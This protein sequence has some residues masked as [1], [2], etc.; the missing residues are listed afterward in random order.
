MYELV[1]DGILV[2]LI[3]DLVVVYLM[4]FG[5]VQWVIVGVDCIVVNGDIVNKIGIYQFVI[6][7]CYYG[8][9]FMVV[10]LFL[11]VDMVMF[12]G[13]VIEIE[14]CDVIELF[15][16]VGQCMVVDGV[17]VWNLV[18]DVM[19]VEL[20][21]VIVIECGVIEWFNVVVMQVVFGG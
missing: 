6:V 14:L 17:E 13:E 3:V 1:C 8:V 5:V 16:I 10:V 7:V 20:I 12:D 2:K 4:K 9:K 21:D 18:F 11:I 15:F 19:L